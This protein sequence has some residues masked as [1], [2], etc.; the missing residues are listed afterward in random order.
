MKDLSIPGKIRFGW[1]LD[2]EITSQKGTV[3]FSVRFWNVDK[4]KDENGIE[5]DA[6]VYSLNTLTSNLHISESLQ[7]HLNEEYSVN[8]PIAEG[9]FKKAII[10]SQLHTENMAIPMNPRFDD[11]GL[12]LNAYESL[13]TVTEGDT[14]KETLTLMAQ[15]VNSDTGELSYEWWYKPA[16]A[17]DFK[18]ASDDTK[19]IASFNSETWYPFSDSVNDDGDV[20]YGFN[21]YGGTVNHNHYAPIV[22][23]DDKEELVAGENYYMLSGGN[24][25]VYDG[26]V[27]RP[28]LYE[29]FTTYTVPDNEADGTIVPVTGQYKVVATNSIKSRVE[30]SNS[31]NTSQPVSSRVCQL[32]SPDNIQFT[33]YGNLNEFEILPVDNEGK[34]LSMDLTVGVANDDSIAAKRTFTWARRSSALDREGGEE[35]VDEKGVLLDPDTTI[36]VDAADEGHKFNV[37]EPGWYQVTVNSTLNR[38]TKTLTSQNCKVTNAVVAPELKSNDETIAA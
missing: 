8:S 31:K 6:V 35:L 27:P 5:K 4:I 10:N 19:V 37:T 15:A 25:V 11:P 22:F 7:P 9:F 38:E 23:E 34:P 13:F 28:Q 30:G 24:Y 36:T 12:N 33:K 17:R 2:S 21:I 16:E 26:S 32:V 14:T 3:K 20:V 29:K 1:P 18:D